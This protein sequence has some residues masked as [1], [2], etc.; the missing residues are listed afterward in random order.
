MH[1]VLREQRVLKFSLDSSR[2]NLVLRQA[3]GFWHVQGI[4]DRP[5]YSRVYLSTNIIVSRVI[6]SVIVDYAAARALPRATSWLE[7]YPWKKNHEGSLG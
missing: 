6:P 7:T 5:G 2:P 3:E 1:T 4:H